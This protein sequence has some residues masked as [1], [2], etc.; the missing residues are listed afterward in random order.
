MHRGRPASERLVPHATLRSCAADDASAV[1]E[2]LAAVKAA[3]SDVL[4]TLQMES[5]L[6]VLTA[7]RSRVLSIDVLETADAVL[8]SPELLRLPELLAAAVRDKLPAA[9]RPQVA[10]RR[11]LLTLSRLSLLAAQTF[12]GAL[13]FHPTCTLSWTDPATGRNLEDSV[14]SQLFIHV[15]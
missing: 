12:A 6:P 11:P 13:F 7:L 15:R 9:A 14:S 3:I 8:R 10:A 4:G 1:R 2:V 5:S